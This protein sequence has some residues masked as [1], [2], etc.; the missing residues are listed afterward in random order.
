MPSGL[1]HVELHCPA[2]DPP[3]AADDIDLLPGHS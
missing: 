2:C 1:A 3:M